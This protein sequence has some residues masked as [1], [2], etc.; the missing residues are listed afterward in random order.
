MRITREQIEERLRALRADYAQLTA[1]ANAVEGAI[2]DCEHW[3][4][5]LKAEPEREEAK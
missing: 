5:V 3:L 1:N 2:Q 4:A